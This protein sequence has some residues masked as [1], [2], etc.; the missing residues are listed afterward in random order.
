MSTFSI[1]VRK[2]EDGNPDTA[3]QIRADAA[4]YV[5][6]AADLAERDA[7]AREQAE[8]YRARLG[9]LRDRNGAQPADGPSEAP[10]Q[11]KKRRQ[12]SR[13]D[14]GPNDVRPEMHGDARGG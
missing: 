1:A 14:G 7:R 11:P 6:P 2:P 8:R 3:D 10:A 13:R 4:A 12:R 5:T 9:E